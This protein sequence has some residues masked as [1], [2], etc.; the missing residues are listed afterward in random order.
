MEYFEII[1]SNIEKVG[2]DKEDQL[3][4]ITF[5]SGGT[6]WYQL[7]SESDMAEFMNADSKGKHFH[8]FI[9]KQF[10]CIKVHLFVQDVEFEAINMANARKV[11]QSGFKQFSRLCEE[12]DWDFMEAWDKTLGRQVWYDRQNEEYKLAVEEAIK[13]LETKK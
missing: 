2:F 3:L 13:Q 11:G 1:S 10:S 9:K 6:Y 4:E 12:N 7:F 8:R 5:K